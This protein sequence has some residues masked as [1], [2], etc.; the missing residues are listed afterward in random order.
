MTRCLKAAVA[1]RNHPSFSAVSMIGRALAITM[2]A[3]GASTA[4]SEESR[5]TEET[6]GEFWTCYSYSASG[7]VTG[8]PLVELARGLDGFEADEG[9]IQVVD[10][11]IRLGKFSVEGLDRTWRFGRYKDG[12][13]ERYAF[14]ITPEGT[15][16]YFD[17]NSMNSQGKASATSRYTCRPRNLAD[18]NALRQAAD[19][20]QAARDCNLE[21]KAVYYFCGTFGGPNDRGRS[22]SACIV[23]ESTCLNEC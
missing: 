22:T 23:E 12:F 15:G 18:K 21:C 10:A 7:E 8:S 4:F 11:G 13:S 16:L 14:S 3:G 1:E 5:Q 2:V 9:I 6:N 19:K 17:F 20:F